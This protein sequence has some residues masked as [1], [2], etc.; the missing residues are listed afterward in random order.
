MV[1]FLVYL[2]DSLTSNYQNA[3][4]ELS[5]G[6]LDSFQHLLPRVSVRRKKKFNLQCQRGGDSHS[7]ASGSEERWWVLMVFTK[8]FILPDLS[9][10]SHCQKQTH[11]GSRMALNIFPV[12]Q[13]PSVQLGP[14]C[15]SLSAAELTGQ[16]R[17]KSG[18]QTDSRSVVQNCSGAWGKQSKKLLVTVV[19]LSLHSLVQFSVEILCVSQV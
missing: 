8:E 5:H 12:S 6:L 13:K 16:L 10:Y 19:L 14:Y 7:A 15:E 11:P 3:R 1:Q 4:C 9:W 17:L 2:I 18:V